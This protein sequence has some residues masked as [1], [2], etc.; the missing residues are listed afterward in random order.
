MRV[1]RIARRQFQA[2][3]GEGARL[4]GGRWNSEGVPVIYTSSTLSLAALEYLVHVDIEDAPD[5]LRAIEIDVPDGAPMEEVS[6]ATLPGD[7]RR[8][9]DHPACVRLGDDWA[10]RGEALALRAPSAVIP[11]ESNVLLN[12]EHPAAASVRVIGSREFSFDPRLL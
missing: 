2:L 4:A 7:W 5:D 8:V 12:P 3:D 10:R 1:W 6:P 9:P 11:E